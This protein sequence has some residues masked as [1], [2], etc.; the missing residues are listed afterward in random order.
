MRFALMYDYVCTQLFREFSV[1]SLYLSVIAITVHV[2]T[3]IMTLLLVII[4]INNNKRLKIKMMVR[5]IIKYHVTGA[6]HRWK[7]KSLL[8]ALGVTDHLRVANIPA[9]F[10]STWTFRDLFP[11]AH[12]KINELRFGYSTGGPGWCGEVYNMIKWWWVLVVDTMLGNRIKGR[13]R[14]GRDSQPTCWSRKY[15]CQLSVGVSVKVFLW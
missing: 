1:W 10:T 3:I 12:V 13:T 5:G 4:I 6:V 7:A 2:T 8:K 11:S 14:A 9:D 15:E